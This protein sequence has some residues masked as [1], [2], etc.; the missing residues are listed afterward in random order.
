[1]GDEEAVDLLLQS[2]PEHLIRD[3]PES[4]AEAHRL[5]KE[6]GYL[7]LAIAQA[8][9]NIVDQQLTLAEYVTLYQDKKQRL[10]LMQSPTHDFQTTDPRNASQS[11]NITWRISFDTLKEQHPL[12]ATF[13]TYIGFFHWRNIPRDLL[14]RLPQFKDLDEPVFIQL[15]KKP[16]NLSLIDENETKSGSVEYMVHP[17]L[18]E[19]I[20]DRLLSV[21]RLSCLAPLADLFY[22]FFPS[23][24]DRNEPD[25]SLA[26]NHFPHAFRIVELCDEVG[27]R[28]KD[29]SIL[30]L[31]LSQF[32]GIS[33]N[34][35]PAIDFAEKAA[36]FGADAWDSVTNLFDFRINILI[37]YSR[38]ARYKDAEQRAREGLEWLNSDPVQAQLDPRTI[39]IYRVRFQFLLSASLVA[40]RPPRL[41]EAEELLRETLDSG[42]TD[43]MGPERLLIAHSLAANSLTS[44][45][46]RRC[47]EV[48]PVV[49]EAGGG[50]GPE[51]P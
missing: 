17:L 37:Q 39:G 7:P 26:L 19:K 38:A 11:V 13:L 45:E 4:R 27:L 5:I 2:I 51:N 30:L 8:A 1:M 31:R 44:R 32:F 36:T 15:T 48:E 29:L 3:R 25:W 9:A 41:K 23:V 22:T 46:S 10:G 18:H 40:D 16:L 20:L 6:L 42:L 14:K 28:G 47:G 24:I 35:T 21:E 49:P 12:S 33:N 50:R 43:E 34:F